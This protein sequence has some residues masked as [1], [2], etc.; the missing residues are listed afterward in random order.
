MKAA[1]WN[2]SRELEIV[3]RDLP[4]TRPGWLRVRLGAV[5]ICGSD[6][7][8]QRGE[9]IPAV[10]GLQ[11]GH[12]MAGTVDTA[13]DG[14]GF[15]PGELV[16]IEPIHGCGSCLYC[17]SGR[18]NLCIGG[19]ML[20][21]LSGNGGMAEYLLAHRKQVYRLAADLAIHLGA[22][23]EPMAVA[24]R[25][26]RL[27]GIGMGSRVAVLGAG[28]IG[29]LCIAAA[30][31]AGAAD[32]LIT[33]R[34]PHQA[35]LARHLGASEVYATSEALLADVGGRLI[36]TVIETVGGTANTM[37]ESVAIASA[38]GSIVMLGLF[39][40]DT[41]FPGLPFLAKELRMFGSNCYAFD[42][43]HSDFGEAVG[44]IERNRDV[45]D[46]LVTHRFPLA[47]VEE[48]FRTAGDKS[49]RSVKVQI[50]P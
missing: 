49:T 47:D 26:V 35:E 7:H 36:D 19:S 4:E 13:G 3:E 16:A 22:L 18:H 48:A 20:M 50:N 11:P 15:A 23:A 25:A 21:G 39:D 34:H 44:L 8:M 14:T 6:L 37:A 5:G 46:P 28:T 9:I 40:G 1:V 29:L 30:K 32:V 41:S 33:A 10:P 27:G 17:R 24:V 42:N 38:G 31:A 12:E 45:L 2:R 43:G